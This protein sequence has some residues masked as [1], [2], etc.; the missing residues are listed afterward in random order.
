MKVARKSLVGKCSAGNRS[1]HPIKMS[2]MMTN[3]SVSVKGSSFQIGRGDVGWFS[4]F[5]LAGGLAILHP[6]IL[7]GCLA[8][9]LTLGFCWLVVISLRRA[10]LEV[11]Q[12]L[13]VIALT[14]YILLSYGFENLAFHIG[15]FPI[16]VSYG[17]MYA[18][19]VLAAFAHRRSLAKA[20]K[21]PTVVC[22]LGLLVLTL[23]HLAVDIPSYGIW[24]IRDS[25]MCLDGIFMILGLLW[26]MKPNSTVFV[27]KWLMVV[28]VLNLFYSFTQPWGEKLWSWSPQSGVFLSVPILG[29]FNGRGDVLMAGTLF[30]ICLGTHLV[31]RRRWLML[32]LAGAQ[33]LGIAI[34]QTRRMYI[35]AVVV[36]II[37]VL[38]GETRKFAKLFS[39]F[40]ASILVILLATTVGGL[41]ISGRVG[42]VNLEFFKE[43]IRSIHDSEGTPGSAVESRFLMADQAFEHFR[44]HPV[45]GVGFGQPLLTDIDENN[46]A[47]T[48]MPH[49]SSITYLTR[50]GL[51][52]FAFWIAFNF[53]LIKR[54]I[55]ALRKR[56][57][58]GENLL[59]A[60]VLW[61]FLFY[62]LFMIASL[63]EGAFEFPSGAVPF[64]FLIGFGLGL[65][66]WQLSNE[67][68]A[69]ATA[70][71]S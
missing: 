27:T 34:A 42:K 23:L 44:E 63:V 6:F 30:C 28:F 25:T 12:L 32:F 3:S 53:L 45:L 22:M 43:H 20:I 39:L 5:V 26:A 2:K 57:T 35:G 33:F 50:L 65:I 1:K 40:P 52:G 62:V 46:G 29:N 51:I 54:F 68:K 56:R 24:A 70:Y 14:G 13:V 17:L 4:L 67:T 37:F 15:G 11:W 71:I 8:V 38:L 7:L 60:F 18:A 55:V 21:E 10:Q 19:L 61:V 69:N 59:S 16:I 58:E 66:R 49:N 64:Y 48:R 47:V 41:D 31:R 36:L 9:A